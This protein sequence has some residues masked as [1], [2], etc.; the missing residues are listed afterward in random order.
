MLSFL[1]LIG[2]VFLARVVNE[3][4]NKTLAPIQKA[5]LIDLFASNRTLYFGLMILLIG[6]YFAVLKWNLLPIIWTMIGY[7]TL[8][9]LS[10]TVNAYLAYRKL[11]ANGFPK[12]YIRLY[13]ASSSIRFVGILLF[14]GLTF[15]DVS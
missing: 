13:L 12:T 3:K 11:N 10:L 6:F 7:F 4:A 14:I 2:S 5:A 15:M 8:L 9:I 1:I